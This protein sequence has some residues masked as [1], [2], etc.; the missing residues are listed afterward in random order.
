[1]GNR[2]KFG[3]FVRGENTWKFSDDG[4]IAYC[5][6]GKEL[7]FFT[8]I[9]SY[10]ELPR[11]SFSKAADGYASMRING[12]QE[13]VHRYISKPAGGEVVDHINRNKKDNRRSNLRNTNKSVNAYNSKRRST[14]TSGRTGVFFRNDT[15]KWAAEIK[16]NGRKFTLGSFQ[17]FEEACM[18]REK[19]E[20]HFYEQP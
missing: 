17:T 5:F 13:M 9:T 8:D 2:D 12:R 15:G 19:A 4:E 20:A 16:N 14:N 7:L 1:M 6:S 11:V 3:R 10:K 18:A